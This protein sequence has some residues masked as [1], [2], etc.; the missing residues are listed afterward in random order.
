MCPTAGAVTV[1]PGRGD[2]QNFWLTVRQH[3]LRDAFVAF[4]NSYFMLLYPS[5]NARE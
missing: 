1:D 5:G 4:F 3:P 2:L